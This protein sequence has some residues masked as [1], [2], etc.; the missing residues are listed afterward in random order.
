L[1]NLGFGFFYC[2]PRLEVIFTRQL[3]S[4]D[5]CLAFLAQ[6][7]SLAFRHDSGHAIFAAYIT[8]DGFDVCDFAVRAHL[9][10]VIAACVKLEVAFLA[11]VT[12][13]VGDAG[14]L[15]RIF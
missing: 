14:V 8:D 2:A 12:I 15:G 13:G 5:G 11:K 7:R 10:E 4:R 3:N 6:W 1:R 9:R